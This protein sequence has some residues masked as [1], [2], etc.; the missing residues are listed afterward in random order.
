VSLERPDL[1]RFYVD[2]LRGVHRWKLA[3]VYAWAG[4]LRAVNLTEGLSV[5][6]LAG[7]VGARPGGF[8]PVR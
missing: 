8:S 5:F 1:R 2:H 4:E 7:H 3:D 6:A